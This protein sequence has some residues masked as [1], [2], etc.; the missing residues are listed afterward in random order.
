M[1]R[2][3][4]TFS[5]L[6]IVWASIEV[7]QNIQWTMTPNTAHNHFHIHL[8][9]PLPP[10]KWMMLGECFESGMFENWLVQLTGGTGR[11]APKSK[12]G[13]YSRPRAVI[14]YIWNSI[15]AGVSCREAHNTCFIDVT[16]ASTFVLAWS[17]APMSSPMSCIVV[18]TNRGAPIMWPPSGSKF[19]LKLLYEILS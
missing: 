9:A 2:L 16:A 10:L 19:N 3:I 8:A 18:Y 11:A 17:L 7:F 15:A 4:W 13:S 12:A 14:G 5:H 6:C 1:L